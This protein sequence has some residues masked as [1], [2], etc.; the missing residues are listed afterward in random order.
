VEGR[1]E[2]VVRPLTPVKVEDWDLELLDRILALK[3]L[4]RKQRRFLMGADLI[5]TEKS[6]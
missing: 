2:M 6:A 5:W 3:D 4:S 1:E